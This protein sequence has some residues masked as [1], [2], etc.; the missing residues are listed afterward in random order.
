MSVRSD[1]SSMLSGS[2]GGANAK[3]IDQVS[4]QESIVRSSLKMIVPAGKKS[5]FDLAV[6]VKRS[7]KSKLNSPPPKQMKSGADRAINLSNI[8]PMKMLGIET[9]ATNQSKKDPNSVIFA[10]QGMMIDPAGNGDFDMVDE[11]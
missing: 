11:K 4:M 3:I 2:M 7:V 10:L 6:R 5:L 9:A 1:K 8:T